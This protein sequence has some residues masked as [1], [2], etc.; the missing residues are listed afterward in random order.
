MGKLQDLYKKLGGRSELPID[1][2][3]P[4]Q[5]GP[6]KAKMHRFLNRDGEMI[7]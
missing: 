1:L 7:R 3:V 2:V 6:S 4:E 5:S